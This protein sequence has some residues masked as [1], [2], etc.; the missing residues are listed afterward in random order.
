MVSSNRSL[1]LLAPPAFIGR[2]P[3]AVKRRK[4]DKDCSLVAAGNFKLESTPNYRNSVL[5]GDGCGS[6]RCCSIS[7]PNLIFIPPTV[8]W[9][10]RCWNDE[11]SFL[12]KIGAKVS[13]QRKLLHCEYTYQ[14]FQFCVKTS[15][16][17]RKKFPDCV[18]FIVQQ[19]KS[20]KLSSDD[21]C[22]RTQSKGFFPSGNR[23]LYL[24]GVYYCKYQSLLA[25]VNTI[26][27]L[28]SSIE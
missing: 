17:F 13:D 25:V 12:N 22:L 2:L 9:E 1:W 14:H 3:L 26:N 6:M 7:S 15:R 28:V 16:T 18:I 19:W 21:W 11:Y 23:N 27:F 8:F 4:G 20:L 5:T 24:I 10:S